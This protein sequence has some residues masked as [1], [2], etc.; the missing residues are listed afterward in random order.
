MCKTNT[1]LMASIW[2]A[3]F[4][5]FAMSHSARAVPLSFFYD[6][7]SLT[8]IVLPRVDDGS[9]QAITLNTAFPFF[10]ASE[11]IAYVS[12]AVHSYIGVIT[13]AATL[14]L[15]A[16]HPS[17]L[18]PEFGGQVGLHFIASVLCM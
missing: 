14:V 13:G 9:S 17:K 18:F 11:T 1:M 8:E 6:A 16:V 4:V 2:T 7:S 15:K 10:G 12:L 5:F 3:V